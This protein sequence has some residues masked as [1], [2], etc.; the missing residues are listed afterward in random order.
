LKEYDCPTTQQ[1]I[2]TTKHTNDK[3][4]KII[5]KIT[6]SNLKTKKFY[7]YI[8]VFKKKKNSNS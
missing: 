2:L 4:C 7:R 6:E 8:N 1:I 3:V 5:N